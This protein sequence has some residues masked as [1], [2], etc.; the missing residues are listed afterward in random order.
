MMCIIS[1][2]WIA[3]VL[4]HLLI[5]SMMVHKIGIPLGVAFPEWKESNPLTAYDEAL[6][7]VIDTFKSRAA[8]ASPNRTIYVHVLA[9]AIGDQTITVMDNVFQTI[10]DAHT[11]I[12]SNSPVPPPT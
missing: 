2:H 11:R 3:F 6:K 12:T 9:T 4:H 10:S 7:K 1:H 8:L 5:S